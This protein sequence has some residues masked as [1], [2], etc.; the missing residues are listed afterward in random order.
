MVKMPVCAPGIVVYKRQTVLKGHINMTFEV[1]DRRLMA[2]ANRPL[3]VLLCPWVASPATKHV[4]SHWLDGHAVE[5]D[6]AEA[7]LEELQFLLADRR[8]ILARRP[9]LARAYRH[10]VRREVRELVILTQNLSGYLE[11]C[12]A[13]LLSKM[14]EREAGK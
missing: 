7:V 2:P 4:A 13:R 5:C 8:A 10:S 9:K 12:K 11:T 1:E 3:A 14:L 6:Q